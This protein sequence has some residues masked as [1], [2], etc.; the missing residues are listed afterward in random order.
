MDVKGVL[1]P[2]ARKRA[3]VLLGLRLRSLL[4]AQEQFINGQGVLLPLLEREVLFN[5]WFTV[6]FSLRA[7]SAWAEALS[8]A[9]VEAWLSGYDLEVSEPK[10]VAVVAAGNLP[11]VG[12]HDALCVLAAGHRL[13]LRPSQ[14]D[15]RLLPWVLA[16]LVEVEPRWA[17]SVRIAEGRMAD[18]NAVIAT[19]SNNSGRYF[20][21]YFGRYP[22]I[23]RG[24]RTSIA[25]LEGDETEEELSGL[26]DDVF[27]YFGMG[28]RSVT[29]IVLP[30]SFDV[31]RLFGAFY[32]F[33]HL[34]HHNAFANNYDYQRSLLL[35]NQQAFLENGFIV[36][37]EREAIH[38]PVGVIH[39]HRYDDPSQ[40]AWHIAA[41]A[42]SLQV[43]SSRRPHFE[44]SCRL[45]QTQ[46][47]GLLDYADG[48]DVMGF[49]VGMWVK[50]FE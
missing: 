20:E 4:S 22:H 40:V 9:S 50:N 21:Y 48:V 42:P 17:D 18:F 33:K 32:R 36:A 11:L 37:L 12:L 5:P 3:L 13:L 7:L 38:S 29:Q 23:I 14:D 35:M 34:Q 39:L 43:V 19:G 30:R 24:N 44:R 49:L 16:L 47:P 28:C 46:N 8:E 10:T 6:E 25:V 27:L 15:A 45:G 31:D 41:H 1:E 2:E 26:A